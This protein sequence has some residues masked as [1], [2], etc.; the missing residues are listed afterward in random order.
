[1]FKKLILA[2]Y[3]V[4]SFHALQAEKHFIVYTPPKCGTF[5]LVKTME[6]ITQKKPYLALSGYGTEID[7]LKL[8][9][10]LR[11]KNQ[12]LVTHTFNQNV[13]STLVHAYQLIFI[14]RDPRDQLLSMSDWMAEGQ[15]SHLQA[16][17]IS[18]QSERISEMITGARFGW[19]CCDDLLCRVNSL[20]P[21]NPMRYTVVRY[22]DLVGPKGGGSLEKQL[23]AVLAI[24]AALEI[25]LSAAQAA[26]IADQIYGEAGIGTFRNGKIGRWRDHFT[27]EHKE[28]FNAQ[29]AKF[30]IK[31]NYSLD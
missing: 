3:F 20:K 4:L 1:M 17:H 31:W 7:L 8:L 22:E 10:E 13:L 18:N 15:W 11:K 26:D 9:K 14:I 5:M 2:V 6:L 21:L 30:L 27:A 19:K 28:L 24:A 25:P 16:A 29:Y 23:E 12:F